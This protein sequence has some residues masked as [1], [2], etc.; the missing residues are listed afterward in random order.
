MGWDVPPRQIWVRNGQRGAPNIMV[1]PSLCPKRCLKHL[2]IA[3]FRVG[4]CGLVV[5]LCETAVLSTGMGRL[6]EREQD[7]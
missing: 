7:T 6:I 2:P 5:K 1:I 4:N 3:V